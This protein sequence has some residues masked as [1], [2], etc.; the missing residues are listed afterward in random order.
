MSSGYKANKTIEKIKTPYLGKRQG[1]LLVT[2]VLISSKGDSDK[3]RGVYKCIC[4]CGNVI[5]VFGT[6]IKQGKCSCGCLQYEARFGTGYRKRKPDRVTYTIQYQN[7][8]RS[9]KERGYIPLDKD[10]WKEM[11]LKE[12]HYC[13]EIDNRNTMA[14]MSQRKGFVKDVTV[15]EIAMYEVPCNGIDRIDSKKGYE[16]DNIVPCCAQCNYMKIQYPQEQF[17]KKAEQI[18]TYTTYNNIELS[19][20]LCN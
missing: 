16:L 17:L 5:E 8:Q 13:G 19:S 18:H 11:V 4:D 1:R 14:Q 3:R 6:Q 10:R 12:C 9:A 7:H 15:E 2:E 20:F